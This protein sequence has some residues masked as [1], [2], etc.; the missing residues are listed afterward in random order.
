MPW[1]AGPQMVLN[2]ELKTLLKK[3]KRK[4]GQLCQYYDLFIGVDTT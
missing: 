4:T 2:L 1:Q 3:E